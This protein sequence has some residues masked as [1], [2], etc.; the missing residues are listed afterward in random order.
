MN[1]KV[2]LSSLLLITLGIGISIYRYSALG[3]N[4]FPK[5]KVVSYSVQVEVKKSVSK[6][7]FRVSLIVPS[8][9]Y[10][11]NI[12]N[13]NFNSE[14][15]AVA[16]F[17]KKD[18]RHI[19]W[20][21][22]TN[23][24]KTLTF[25]YTVEI[26]PGLNNLY[27]SPSINN[28]EY[29]PPLTKSDL[30]KLNKFISKLN[31]DDI[32]SL[33]SLKQIKNCVLNLNCEQSFFLNRY[34]FSNKKRALI[35]RYIFEKIGYPAL[36][37]RA[38]FVNNEVARADLNHFVRVKVNDTWKNYFLDNNYNKQ[39]K[40]I[41]WDYYQQ[42]DLNKDLKVKYAIST[43]KLVGLSYE[44]KHKEFKHGFFRAISLKNLS[45]ATQNSFRLLLLFPIGALIICILRNIVGLPTFGTFLPILVAISFRDM[46]LYWGIILISILISA[47]IIVRLFL[48]KLRLLM[49]PR[50]SATLTIVILL[51]L[52]FTLLARAFNFDP[53]LTL[54]Y[55]PLVIVT[56]LIERVS[57]SIDE[58]GL[59]KTIILYLSTILSSL[60]AFLVLRSEGLTYLVTNYP[61]FIL[62]VLGLIILVGR[63]TGLR[64]LEYY[65]FRTFFK[66]TAN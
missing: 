49:V 27:D 45:V 2:L 53:G 52:I 66:N 30:K 42:N 4:F 20:T 35:L 44:M 6:G 26:K 61:E 41:F 8:K 57:I 59:K 31:N 63:Y 19:K 40:Y 12:I 3:I 48:S 16:S 36:I 25:Y 29:S 9:R 5:I 11:P 23:K 17:Y 55:F 62:S 18:K 65:R 51:I 56:L 32:G 1:F 14:G 60:I 38:F 28:F 64:L 10:S 15:Y 39:K 47:G 54:H 22:K 34:K 21:G 33:N 24:K 58:I 13:E 50:V 7:D 46:G 43:Q 37:G